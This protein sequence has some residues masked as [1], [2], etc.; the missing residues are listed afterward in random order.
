MLNTNYCLDLLTTKYDKNLYDI[1]FITNLSKNAIENI[2][3]IG[4]SVV[5]QL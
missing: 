2:I 4:Y 1:K 3:F 5:W